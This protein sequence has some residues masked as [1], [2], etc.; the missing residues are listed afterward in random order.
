MENSKLEIRNSK[1]ERR[2]SPRL[3]PI[4]ALR[5]RQILRISNFEFRI[6]L[7]LLLAPLRLHAQTPTPIL[8][9]ESAL[10]SHLPTVAI[11]KLQEFLASNPSIDDA[12]RQRAEMDLTHAILDSGDAAGAL[13]RLDFPSTDTERFWKAEALSALDRWDDAEPLYGEVAEDGPPDLRDAA[14]IGEAEALETLGRTREAINVLAVM[15]KRS[16]STLVQ[17][18]LAELSIEDQR[19]DAARKLVAN[20][21]PASLIEKNWAKYIEGRIYLA[22]D[23]AAPALE[24]FEELLNNPGGLTAELHAAATVGKC[25]AIIVL[26]GY[27]V[28][29]DVLE[30]YITDY[31]D[32]PY[33]EDMFRRLSRIYAAE[34]GPSDAQLEHW[35]QQQPAGRAALARYYLGRSLQNQDRQ[36]KAIRAYTEFIQSYPRHPYAFDAWMQLGQLYLE[37]S[38]IPTAISAF[39]GA[40]RS[41]NNAEERARGEIATGNAY[42]AQG[43][44]LLAAETFH[45][46]APRSS[47]LWLEATYDSALA[48]ANLGN[49][50]RFLEDYN[51][52]PDNDEKHGLLFE[53]GLLQAR[54]H[55]PRAPA[56]LET[57]IRDYPD[58]RRVPEARLALA[59]LVYADGDMDGAGNL[60]KAAYLTVDPSDPSR[61]RDDYLAIFIADSAKDRKD[62]AVIRLGLQFLK[63]YP[64]SA[65]RPQVRMKLGQVYF[66]LEDFANAQTQFENLAQESP[67]DPLADQALILAGQSAVRAMS[68]E[69]I[70]HA[71]DLYDRVANGTGPLRLYARQE[72]AAL[73]AQLGNNKDAIIFYDT[74]LRSNPDTQ[75]RLAALCG[76]A[77]CLIAGEADAAAAAS[78]APAPSASPT[79]TGTDANAAAIALYD[80]I[81]DDPDATASWR[82][83][84]LFKKGRC[85]ARQG[86]A[87][88]ALAAY[89]DVLNSHSAASQKQQPDF[90]WFEKAGYAAAEMLEDK[91]QW[92]GAI[93]ILEKIAQAG[94]PRSAEARKHADQLPARA[95]CLGLKARQPRMTEPEKLKSTLRLIIIK[96]EEGLPLTG[97]SNV[98]LNLGRRTRRRERANARG[99]SIRHNSQSAI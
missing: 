63:D 12:T 88:P 7:L 28:A 47:D 32:S 55:D 76:K 11:E 45:D 1:G 80:Q 33:L 35:I 51:A 99:S 91:S 69:G 74:I 48:W 83:E 67:N 96:V 77:D 25:E 53:E 79:A 9:A 31:P 90:F 19:I 3:V 71:L 54:S 5:A 75:L 72:Q 49:Y 93:S 70:K 84:A 59:E 34:S 44:F 29:D 18:R 98:L 89:Y 57:F 15:E 24:D 4:R 36:E 22:E 20:A 39:E 21:K 8:S 85:L 81:K 14:A 43:E 10:D 97:L 13:A 40:M 17:L 38:S 62:D 50:D 27:E 26:N 73:E 41:S 95:F 52:L 42:F 46:A 16:P 64:H 23:Q 30:N 87:D 66:R 82:D 94:G 65:L 37:R 78:P 86:L 58:N 2:N 6:F 56:T 68:T 61:E 92:S 60:L